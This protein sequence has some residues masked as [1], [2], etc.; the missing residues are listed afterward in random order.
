M[1]GS[2]VSELP[3][4][5]DELLD[6]LAAVGDAKATEVGEELVAAVLQLYGEGFARVVAALRTLPHGEAAVR[7][8]AEDDL[9]ASLLLLHDLHPDDVDVRIQQA[10]DRVRPYLGSHAGGVEY[11]GVDA[12]GVAQL[13]LEGSCDGCAGSAATVQ[14]AIERAVLTAAPEV[15]R[16]EVAGVRAEPS[17]Q[18]LQ[19]GIR[20]PDGLAEAIGT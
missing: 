1:D 3:G 2:D 19:I 7:R 10:L 20:C 4:R 13:R 15:I 5:I 14:N 9:V 16:V 18:L 11:V 6:Q 12:E 17:P 8:I